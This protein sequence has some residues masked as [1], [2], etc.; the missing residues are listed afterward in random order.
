MRKI[1]IT[2]CLAAFAMAANAQKK[3]EPTYKIEGVQKIN[4]EVYQLVH[5]PAN[6]NV[7]VVGP[8]AGF[9]KNAENFVYVLN[10]SSLAVIDSISLGKKLPFGIAI[11]NKTQTLYVGHA[12]Q[13][14]VSVVDIKSKTQKVI[15]RGHEK[16]KIRELAVDEKRNLVYVSDHG[17]SSVWVIDGATNSLKAPLEYPDSYLLGLNVDADRGKIYTT[18]SNT[19]EGN[20]LVFDSEKNQLVN[21]F[22]TWSYCPLNIAIDYK[23]NRLFVS[24]SNDNNVTVVDGNTGEIIN[25]VYL[26]YDTSPIGLVYDEK[27]NVVYTANRSK[28]EVAVIDAKEYKVIER[29]PTLGLPNTIS[30]DKKTGAIYVTNKTSRTPDEKLTNTNAVVKITKI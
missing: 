19:M 15:E 30:L 3:P 9:N 24:Q 28:K 8:K 27:L 4:A 18:D 17:H 20:I 5:N 16:G 1:F 26:G 25:K 6:G 13:N 21:K 29:I 10:G 11:N 14:A 22:K 2:A 12:T 23:N 7:Y